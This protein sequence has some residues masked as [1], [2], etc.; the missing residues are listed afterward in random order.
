[1]FCKKYKLSGKFDTL[2]NNRKHKARP[3]TVPLSVPVLMDRINVKH[4]FQQHGFW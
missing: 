1:M 4:T 3:S 2:L